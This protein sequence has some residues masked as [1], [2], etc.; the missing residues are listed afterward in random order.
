LGNWINYGV[1]K[2]KV[3]IDHQ[4]KK[5]NLNASKLSMNSASVMLYSRMNLYYIP[6]IQNET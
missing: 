3:N 6:I 1:N 5:W 2:K 4:S